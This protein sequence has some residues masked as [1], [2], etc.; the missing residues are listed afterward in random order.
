VSR[1][2]EA[3]T[4]PWVAWRGGRGQAGGGRGRGARA[5]AWGR[6]VLIRTRWWQAAQA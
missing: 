6:L 3:L 2:G 1:G 5:G 4:R